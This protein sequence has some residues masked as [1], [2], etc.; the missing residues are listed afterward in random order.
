[1][2]TVGC[3]FSTIILCI[4]SIMFICQKGMQTYFII[5]TNFRTQ[6]ENLQMLFI[7]YIHILVDSISNEYLDIK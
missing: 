2:Y 6:V 5:N 1:M 3:F 7:P 4:A